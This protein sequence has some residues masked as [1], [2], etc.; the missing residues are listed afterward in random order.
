MGTF[1]I[2]NL[3]RIVKYRQNAPEL[4][5]PIL[6]RGH[7]QVETRLQNDIL[8]EIASKGQQKK[9]DL[10]NNLGKNYSDISNAV[11]ILNDKHM[12]YVRDTK[13]G[14]GRPRKFYSLTEQG[15]ESITKTLTVTPE[16]FWRMIFHIA[17]GT[18]KYRNTIDKIFSDYERNV[19]HYSRKFTPLH[20][21]FPSNFDKYY[22][23]ENFNPE[24]F[25]T[26]VVEIFGYK[27][28]LTYRHLFKNLKD[29]NLVGHVIILKDGKER[30]GPWF[31]ALLALNKDKRYRLSL[32][33]LVI[34]L[35]ILYE[36]Y[37]SNI[38]EI[39]R[40]ESSKKLRLIA[41]NYY[42]L[43]PLIF[44]KLQFLKKLGIDETLILES[45]RPIFDV[46]SYTPIQSGGINELLYAQE[47]MGIFYSQKVNDEFENGKSIRRELFGNKNI[48]ANKVLSEIDKQIFELGVLSWDYDFKSVKGSTRGWPLARYEIESGEKYL[49]SMISFRFYT[50]LLGKL[51]N[52]DP[53]KWK[54]FFDKE[55]KLKKWY[56]DWIKEIN[57]FEIENRKLLI[58]ITEKLS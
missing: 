44:G 23:E 39:S 28:P 32:F 33:G 16:Q 41:Q 54:W 52:F 13:L 31:N 29:K 7:Q 20:N 56:L 15:V 35:R 12:I 36:R 58:K 51:Y 21:V 3:L 37:S 34:L 22:K 27:G 10:S 47:N 42:N 9:T 50:Y 46:E 14:R 48:V 8:C 30:I 4:I 40:N 26:K 45:F 24:N 43:L 55:P 2:N 6:K 17:N 18:H 5:L 1:F 53:E 11:D 57:L 19:L 25:A 38:S 49:A